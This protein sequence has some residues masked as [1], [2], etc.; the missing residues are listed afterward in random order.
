MSSIT[1]DPIDPPPAPAVPP[2]GAPAPSSH[3]SA[4]AEKSST[5]ARDTSHE[6]SMIDLD[7]LTGSV[8]EQRA[9][10]IPAARGTLVALQR[11]HAAGEQRRLSRTLRTTRR[12]P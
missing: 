11:A 5:P 8:A 2:G 3:A 6:L 4:D 7:S 12:R 1:A 9:G 10:H